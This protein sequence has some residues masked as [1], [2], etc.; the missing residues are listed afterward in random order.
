MVSRREAR[1]YWAHR[2]HATVLNAIGAA[3]LQSQVCEQ[4]VRGALPSSAEEVVRLRRMLLL[5]ED[6][7]RTLTRAALP[8]RTGTL[9]AEVTR[10][11]EATRRRGLPV[12]LRCH[13]ALRAAS[14]RIIRGTAVVL[15][16][17]LANA[18]RH[19][20]ATSVEVE[21]TVRDGALLLRVRDDG[22]GCDAA[23][24][25]HGPRAGGRCGIEIMRAQAAALDGRLELSSAAG[26]GTQVSLFVPL[27]P[28]A[29]RRPA[30]S[31][32]VPPSPGPTSPAA[33][34]SAPAP[35]APALWIP[36]PT[37]QALPARAPRASVPPTAAPPEEAPPGE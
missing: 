26:R 36:A 30:G 29:R 8:A 1:V 24:V 2:L 21:V 18:A 37:D 19:A 15:A 31:A 16:E 34:A 14:P 27:P 33:T 13:G 3:I 12:H 9:R 35:Q 10:L 11:V 22:A 17:A 5:L 20:R 7:A 4:A 25:M 23:T 28:P 6:E 32:P